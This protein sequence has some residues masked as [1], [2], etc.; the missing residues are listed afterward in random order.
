MHNLT[1]YQGNKYRLKIYQSA[2]DIMSGIIST[3]ELYGAEYDKL[4]NKFDVGSIKQ[5]CKSIYNFLLANT[6]YVVEPNEKQTLRSPSAILTLGANPRIGVDCKSYSLFIGGILSALQRKGKNIDWCYRFASYKMTDSIPHHVFI[7]INPNQQDEFYVDPVIQPF[8]YKKPYFYSIDKK[9]NMALYAISG[10]GAKKK[11][12]SP[13]QQAKKQ[14]A[15]EK[16][17]NAIKKAGKVVVKY[18]PPTLASRNAFL[19]LVKLNVFKLANNLN[20][21]LRQNPN[22]LERFWTKIGGNFQSLK[23]NIQIGNKKAESSIGV[24]DPATATAGAVATA[25]PILV[26]VREFLKKLGLT[27]K[28]IAGLSKFAGDVVKDAIDKKADQIADGDSGSESMAME[29]MN[30]ASAPQTE[31]TILPVNAVKNNMPL[32]LGAVALVGGYFLLKRK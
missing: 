32:I 18:S 14:K 12:K 9:P 27:D 1:P 30:E 17:V 8:E 28:D 21:A 20:Q 22:E 13:E 25:T 26:A 24:V 11:R 19:L 6:N 4:A 5:I 7:V 16:I 2:G 23:K 15:K 31:S 3:H 10:I 29:Q